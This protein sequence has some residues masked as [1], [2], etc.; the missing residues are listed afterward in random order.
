MCHLLNSDNDTS[1]LTYAQTRTIFPGRLIYKISLTFCWH[2]TGCVPTCRTS[3]RAASNFES[4][5]FITSTKNSLS[6]NVNVGILTKSER[7]PSPS[8][9]KAVFKVVSF[10]E[11]VH[12]KFVRYMTSY[13]TASASSLWYTPDELRIMVKK[14]MAL[15]RGFKKNTGEDSCL[16]FLGL[17]TKAFRVKRRQR[18]EAARFAFLSQQQQERTR[19]GRDA[20]PDAIPT[21]YESWT[22]DARIQAEERGME[23]ALGLFLED[24]RSLNLR[25]E[26]VLDTTNNA[27][28]LT[29]RKEFRTRTYRTYVWTQVTLTHTYHT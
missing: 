12:V 10:Q 28:L 1:F 29:F 9:S 6:T 17:E 5:I 4:L 7:C 25:S 14:H 16:S 20:D 8:E 24:A 15:C 2:D 26:G 13:S 21:I 11:C 23:L 18:V 3:P 27:S 19:K 22:R